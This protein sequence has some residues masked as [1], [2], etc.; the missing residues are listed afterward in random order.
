MDNN[1]EYNT[2][3]NFE[4]E[5]IDENKD[6]TCEK[7]VIL[8][9]NSNNNNN[10]IK[11]N[12]D[13]LLEKLKDKNINWICVPYEML[14]KEFKNICSQKD[15][16]KVKNLKKGYINVPEDW[17]YYENNPAFVTNELYDI[18]KNK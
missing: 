10:N 8:E 14:T 6:L 13:E 17:I 12:I 5:I 15:Y 7:F 18:F 4:Y 11:I 3:N 9:N 1:T 2:D 16:P